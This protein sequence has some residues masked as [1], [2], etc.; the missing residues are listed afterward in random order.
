MVGYFFK[1]FDKTNLQTIAKIT[2]QRKELSSLEAEQE[3]INL[4][5]QDLK[6]MSGN[7]LQPGDLFSRDVTLVKEIET[8]E[9]LGAKLKVNFALSGLSDTV[10]SASK[11]K[12]QGDLVT[13]PYSINLNGP[14][15]R[16]VDFIETMENLDFITHLN[17]MSL[18]SAD[19]DT[20]TA[21]M[22]AIFYLQKQ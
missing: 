2:E 21:N 19:N 5:K 20:V 16:V 22:T 3:S 7:R 10:Q 13:V 15:P 6:T 4:A 18:S 11:A 12:T 17:T 8:L 9:N 14:F 1:I